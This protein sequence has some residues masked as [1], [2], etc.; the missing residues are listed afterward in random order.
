MSTSC[1]VARVLRSVA[2]PRGPDTLHAVVAEPAGHLGQEVATVVLAHGAGGSHLN[3]YRQVDALSESFRVIA[4]DQR[5]FGASTGPTRVPEPAQSAGDLLAVLDHLREPVDHEVHLVGQ[6]LGGW[7]LATAI[8][9]GRRP[10]ASLTL[11]GSIGGMFTPA[12]R[13]SLEVFAESARAAAGLPGT[14]GRSAAL[15]ARSTDQVQPD[16]V[17]YQLLGL[18]P[19]PGVT[20]VEKLLDCTVDATAL[21]ETAVPV[22]FVVGEL[23]TIFAPD[24]VSVVA[25]QLPG[26]QLSVIAGAGHS[27]Y[28]ERP[29]EFNATLIR[30]LRKVGPSRRC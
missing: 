12:T 8:I 13:R 29:E 14:I 16:T 15:A 11:S 23:D 4:W 26:S 3:F 17:L 22:L 1:S 25:G 28:I 6:S 19:G 30:F 2:I 27:P 18:L 7:A 5:G 20:A 21:A 10:F 9:A 24:D